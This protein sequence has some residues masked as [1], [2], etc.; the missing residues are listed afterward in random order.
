MESTMDLNDTARVRRPRDAVE[1]RLGTVTDITYAPHT[2]YIRRLRLRFPTGDERTYT[3]AEITPCTR[4]DDRAALVAALIEGCRSL[5]DAYRIAHDYDEALSGDIIGLLIAIYDITK[6]RLGV[7]IDPARLPEHP[8][9]TD[10]ASEDG[11]RS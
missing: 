6:V 7:T 4:E 3:T 2:T 8:D 9:R 10:A 5:R 1:Y 11:D